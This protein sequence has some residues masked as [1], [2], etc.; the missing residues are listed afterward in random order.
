[1]SP[2]HKP[3]VVHYN[4]LKPCHSVDSDTEASPDDND[5]ERADVQSNDDHESDIESIEL[6]RGKRIRR[7]PDWL[8]Y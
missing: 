5:A 6:G 8:I 3:H 4:R 7:P 1:M 2:S